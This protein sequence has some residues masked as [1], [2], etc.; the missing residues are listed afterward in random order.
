[1]TINPQQRFSKNRPCPICGGHDRLARGIGTRCHGF[2]SDDGRF[3]HCTREEF[4]GALERNLTSQTFA[5]RLEGPCGCGKVHGL[6]ESGPQVPAPPEEVLRCKILAATASYYQSRLCDEARRHLTEERKLPEEIL[7]RFQVGWAD[8]RLRKHLLEEKG[9]PLEACLKAGVLKQDEQGVRDFFFRRIIF[10]NIVGSRVVHLSGRTLDDREPKWLHL[11]GEITHPYNAD[12]LRQ[13]DCVWAEGIPDV[14]SAEAQGHPAAAGLGTHCKPE[15]ASYAPGDHRINICLDGDEAG[16]DGA[17]QAASV[18]GRRSRIMSLPE[19]KDVNDLLREGRWSEF[20]ACVKDAQD[21]LTFSITRIPADAPKTE[22]PGFLQDILKEMAAGDPASAEAYLDVI[23]AR[24]RLKRDEVAAYRRMIKDLRSASEVEARQPGAVE[25]EYSA[26]FD[27]LV[28]LVEHEGQPA[29]LVS[30]DGRLRTL[31]TVERDGRVL[32]PPSRE[33]IPWLLP[34]EEEVLRW[35]QEDSDSQLYD[36]LIVYYRAAS[37]LPDEPHYELIAL[38]VLH[39]YLLERMQFSP[40]LC[41]FAVPERGKTRTGKAITYVAYR[42]IHVESLRDP[43]IVRFAAYCGG[44]IFFDVM[45]LWR[46][47]QR[48]GSEDILLGRYERGFTVPRVLFPDRGPHQDTRYFPIFGPTV[49]ATNEAIHH[50]LETRAVTITMSEARRRF[51]TDVTPEGARPLRERLVAFR[52]RHLGEPLPEAGKPAAGRLG[53][54]LKPL[55]QIARLVRPDREKA[56]LAFVADLRRERRQEKSETLEGELLRVLDGLREKVREDLLPVRLVTQALNDGRPE[57]EQVSDQKVGRRL[58]S[59]GFEKGPRSREGATIRWDEE[60]LARTMAAYGLQDSTHSAH[61]AP[62]H[63]ATEAVGEECVECEELEEE[64][65]GGRAHTEG[66]AE[67]ADAR[68][69][70]RRELASGPSERP[71]SLA[72]VPTDP[73]RCGSIRF[74]RSIHGPVVCARCHPPGSPSLAAEWFDLKGAP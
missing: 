49:I 64:A 34:R 53:D 7:G 9:L 12:A 50:I 32:S 31:T 58:R 37:E 70:D 63:A 19:G 28:D 36:D 74:W 17:L 42:G 26:V 54:I 73:C 46:K 62:N 43:Y 3:A 52:A 65:L 60:K 71:L 15:W 41:L 68:P 14:F 29:F 18:F 5:H 33:Q 27:G 4:A 51:E 2:V 20:E 67:E 38:W 56:F 10:P 66:L 16:Q 6:R 61:S 30:E 72:P 11:P 39:T 1:M 47:A 13:R 23:K 24:F 59:L 25:A 8:G 35:V 22:L 57:R 40:E 21:P 45:N 44:T 55:R 69:E 48:E